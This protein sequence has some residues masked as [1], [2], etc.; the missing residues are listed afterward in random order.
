MGTSSNFSCLCHYGYGGNRCEFVT[1][2]GQTAPAPPAQQQ[3]QS[4]VY[5]GQQQQGG[6]GPA[7]QGQYQQQGYQQQGYQHQQYQQ[8]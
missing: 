8:G 6:Y 1:T 2:P 5:S 4:V 3:A 7:A